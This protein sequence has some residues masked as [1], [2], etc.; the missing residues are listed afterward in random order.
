AMTAES[1]P[2]KVRRRADA[3]LARA[4]AGVLACALLAAHGHLALQLFGPAASWDAVWDDEPVVS[5]RHPL[6]YYHA[7]LSAL[8]WQRSHSFVCFDPTFQAGYPK[9]PVFDGGGRPA[10]LSALFAGG[11][12]RP[13]VYKVGLW[14]TVTLL[15]AC[16]WFAAAALGLGRWTGLLAL[17]VAVLAVWNDPA[18]RLVEGGDVTTV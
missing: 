13:R 7:G 16:F 12:I 2:R 10:E 15:P 11:P 8:A 5:G 3:P 4:A 6:H 18:R 14:L 17:G 9:T 1:Q